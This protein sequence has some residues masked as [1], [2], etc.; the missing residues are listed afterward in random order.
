MGKKKWRKH[1]VDVIER[2]RDALVP[3]DVLLGGGNIKNLKEL[4]PGCR[5]GDNADAF[6]GGFR[7]WQ[8]SQVTP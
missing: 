3:D 2:L 4:P 5:R 8:T 6:A 1:V 7:L